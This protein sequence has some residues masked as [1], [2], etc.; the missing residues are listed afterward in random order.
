MSASRLDAVYRSIL[1]TKFFTKGWG[2]PEN[3]KRSEP[4]NTN[5]PSGGQNL[6]ASNH[7]CCVTFN[8]CIMRI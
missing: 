7:V 3:L 5:T 2:K 8:S 1:L 4:Q 6:A